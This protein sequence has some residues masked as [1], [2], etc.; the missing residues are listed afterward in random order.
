MIRYLSLILFAL[1]LFCVLGFA[2]ET[3]L[4][5]ELLEST[6]DQFK[7]VLDNIGK[8]VTDTVT[9]KE[10]GFTGS[11]EDRI[12]AEFQA[13]QTAFT[14]ANQASTPDKAKALYTTAVLHYEKVIEQ[15]SVRRAELY[16]NLANA[17]LLK[18]DIGR[19]ILNYRRA[20]KLH[21]ANTDI[22]KNL[23]F[24]RTKRID[25]VAVKTQQKVLKTL[26]FWHYDFS[27]NARFITASICFA[28]LF[29]LFT[30]LI[31]RGRTTGIVV[32]C[33]VTVLLFAAFAGSIAV[34]TF[35]S[36]RQKAGVIISPSVIARQ[37][38]GAN[39]SPSFKDPLHSGTEFDLLESRPGW[40]KIQL[41]DGSQGWI[42]TNS[43][44]LI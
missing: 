44:E 16:Y 24:A 28:I 1:L 29:T 41:S 37:G 42:T 33:V 26:F 30:I 18:D 39:Y 13:A 34:E 10:I 14:Q 5:L 2:E 36:S 38:D 25:A 31:W 12:V 23:T 4:P 32:L 21:P 35:S 19:A 9:D 27:I 8:D 15:G 22:L 11:A 40:Y 20:E 3:N 6:G 17:Y 7:S 43:A